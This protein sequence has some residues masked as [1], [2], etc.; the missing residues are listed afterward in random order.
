MFL[1]GLNEILKKCTK[2]INDENELRSG[3]EMFKFTL[4]NQTKK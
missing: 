1:R 3:E 2:K 4:S